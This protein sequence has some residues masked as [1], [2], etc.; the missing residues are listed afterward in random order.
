MLL[1]ASTTTKGALALTKTILAIDDEPIILD[2][3]VRYL[4]QADYQVLTAVN[5]KQGLAKFEQH[6]IDLIIT[7]IMLP[8][9]D[10][11]EMMLQILDENPQIPFLF[12]TAKTREQDRLYG[13]TLGADDYIVK[14]FSPRE[15]ILRVKNILRRQTQATTHQITMGPLMIDSDTREATLY[16][17]PLSLTIKEFDLLYF[18]ASNPN[19][20]YS[21]SELFEQVWGSDFMT[22]AN[23]INVH[24]HYL[25]EKMATAGADQPIPLIQTVWGLGY[26]L[27]FETE[28]SS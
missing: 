13:L 2:T 14:P 21:K 23:T 28:M 12:V 1:T 20:V 7:D 10:G 8:E 26:K 19:H 5:G 9:M 11:Y 25:R 16:S 22:D 18:L 6:S 4:K 17:N 24:V 27:T 3:I 15:L